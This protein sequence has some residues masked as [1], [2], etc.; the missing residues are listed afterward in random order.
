MG[1]DNGIHLKTKKKLDLDNL[2]NYV[3]IDDDT[4][5]F[6]DKSMNVYEICYWRNCWTTRSEI[7]KNCPNAEEDG[8][9]ELN[10]KDIEEL[11]NILVGYLKN[12]ES[13]DEGRSI[14]DFNE[15]MER[16]AQQVV[17][18]GWLLTYMSDKSNQHW[19]VE[20]YDSY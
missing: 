14:W 20:F 10:I 19:I 16:I 11:Q 4:E 13:W 9:S 12:P 7:L 2:P 1:L 3:H 17:N 8:E 5:Y 18:L 6:E 15:M